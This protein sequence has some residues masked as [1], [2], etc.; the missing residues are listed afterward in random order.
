MTGPGEPMARPSEQSIRDKTRARGLSW[1]GLAS[2]WSRIKTGT[3]DDW[4]EGKALEHL[5]IRAFELSGL[6]VEYPYDVPPGGKPLEQ[7]DGLVFL[8][9]IPFLLECKDE[10]KIDVEPIAKLYSK[11]LRRPPVTMGC[12]FIKGE[13]TSPALTLADHMIPHRMILWSGDDID[14]A[15]TRRDF[16]AALWEKYYDLC[17]YG[18]MDHSSH[19]RATKVEAKDA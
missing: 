15:L 11:L 12:V 5:V 18:L 17:R 3:T 6:R 13:F 1:D 7:I 16:Q 19:F 14:T 9:D 10:E 4:H 2:L 8:R